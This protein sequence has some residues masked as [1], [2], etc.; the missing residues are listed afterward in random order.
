MYTLKDLLDM[1]LVELQKELQQ[2]R[3]SHSSMTIAVKLGKE[4][5]TAELRTKRRYV[6][7]IQTV[8]NSERPA[9]KEQ[10]PKAVK[11]SKKTAKKD[12]K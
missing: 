6:A 5:N 9:S 4:K 11:S 1:S 8:M 10:A 2:A 7:Q 3:A 12:N